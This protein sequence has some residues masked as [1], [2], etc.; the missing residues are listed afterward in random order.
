MKIDITYRDGKLEIDSDASEEERA[1]VDRLKTTAQH[2]QYVAEDLIRGLGE[3]KDAADEKGREY[4]RR[5]ETAISHL[6]DV[7]GRLVEEGKKF[8]LEVVLDINITKKEK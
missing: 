1:Y 5:V 7:T 4:S 3:E 2:F 8:G 6:R